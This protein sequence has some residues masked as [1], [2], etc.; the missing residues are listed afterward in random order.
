MKK[1]MKEEVIEQTENNRI[2]IQL[3]IRI[4]KIK[5]EKNN[6]RKADAYVP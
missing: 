1:E 3:V 2:K 5:Q 6:P 4:F